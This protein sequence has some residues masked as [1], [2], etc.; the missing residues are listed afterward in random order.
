VTVRVAFTIQHPAHVHLFRNAIRE[1]V[2]A[3]DSVF[4]F[5]RESDVATDLLE[6]YGIE[7]SRLAPK[8]DSFAELAVAQV[9]YESRLL[10]NCL[11]IDPDVIVGMGEPGVAHVATLLR[12][13]GLLFTDTE[14]ATIQNALAFPFA[15]RI[16]TPDCFQG[17]IGPKQRRYPGYHELAYL[18]PDRFTPDESVFDGTDVDPDEKLVVLRLVAWNA[19]HDIGSG[20]FDDLEAVIECLESTG[21]RVLLTSEAELPDRLAEYRVPTDPEDVHHLLHYADLFIGESSTMA[22]EA[23][24]LGTPALYVSTLTTG[25][26]DE[27]QDEYGLVFRYGDD[28]RQERALAE[29]VSILEDYDAEKWTRRRDRLL[30]DKVDTTRVLLDQIRDMG[31]R[32]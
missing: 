8:A 32:A 30:D 24:V 3:G 26:I 31:G 13:N 23:A 20:G 27:L 25:Y 9:C 15:D 12:T 7:Y 6:A 17:D 21:A 28:D 11:K 1:L 4:V 16:C 14:G 19:L 5:V 22:T 18:H 2:G 10:R 29:A